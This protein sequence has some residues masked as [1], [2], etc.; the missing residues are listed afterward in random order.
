M[1]RVLQGPSFLVNIKPKSR[2]QSVG[3]KGG[4]TDVAS[5]LYRKGLY[6]R[7]S[8][9]GWPGSFSTCGA[10]H[11]FIPEGTFEMSAIKSTRSSTPAAIK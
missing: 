4:V 7:G 9:Q 5:G 8:S 3:R 11:V 2:N 10:G 6:K 1:S